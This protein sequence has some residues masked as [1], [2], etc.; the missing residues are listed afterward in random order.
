VNRFL[1]VGIVLAAFAHV[2]PAAIVVR[3]HEVGADL[4]VDSSGTLDTGACSSVGFDVTSNFNGIN[5]ND[6]VLA[7]GAVSSLQDQCNGTAITP[8]TA[9]GPGTGYLNATSNIGVSYYFEP[10][11]GFWGPS[12]WNSSTEFAASMVIA[13]TSFAS[14]GLTLGTYEYTLSN[15]AVSDTLTITVDATYTPVA[16]TGFNFDGIAEATPAAS[17]TSTGLDT[18][19][20]VVY[21]KAY[22]SEPSIGTGLGL[23][24]NGQIVNDAR[25]YQL[26]SYTG[27][28][29]LLLTA[30]DGT[31]TLT[32]ATPA[33]YSSLSLLGFSTDGNS[34]ATFTLHFA[35]SSSASFSNI[36]APDWFAGTGSVILAGFDRT[37][38][39]FDAAG[40]SSTQ[41]YLYAYDLNL[42]AALRAKVLSAIDVTNTTSGGSSFGPRIAV[43]A[44]SGVSSSDEIFADDFE[45]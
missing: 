11:A 27:N 35:D 36:S 1:G 12:G 7:F 29:V 16:V 42:Q 3:I 21:S 40:G 17:T 24:D 18:A 13:N 30:V 19:G 45:Q 34:T 22:G 8:S 2:A 4:V 28:N 6:T 20:Y 32:L 25:I 43:F 38:R 10:S 41:P 9:L 44:V 14:A 5:A 39:A 31:A 15:G 33:Q 37:F 26:Q 23:P